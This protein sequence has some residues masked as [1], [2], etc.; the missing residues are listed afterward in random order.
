MV[1]NGYTL[2]T[3][4]KSFFR[5]PEVTNEKILVGIDGAKVDDAQFR[6]YVLLIDGMSKYK[7]AILYERD[8]EL[9]CC[10]LD[11]EYYFIN[12]RDFK[13]RGKSLRKCMLTTIDIS[14]RDF[15]GGFNGVFSKASYMPFHAIKVSVPT[16]KDLKMNELRYAYIDENLVTQEVGVVDT[17]YN[18]TCLI[19]REASENG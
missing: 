2:V 5:V 12:D 18:Y 13:F 6:G 19:N 4:S 16:I 14:K 9:Y 15:F 1:I 10:F 7:T 17:D 8:E 3:I 11:P